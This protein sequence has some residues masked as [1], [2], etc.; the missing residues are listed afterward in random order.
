MPE[1]LLLTIKIASGPIVGAI[2]GFF[3]NWLAVKMLFRPYK[4]K[5]IGKFR[6]PFTPGIIPKRKEALGRALGKAVGTKLITPEDLKRLF[7]GEEIKAKIGA[8]IAD[9]VCGINDEVTARTLVNGFG[10]G[11]A[12]KIADKASGFISEKMV[13]AVK[14][15]DL[16]AL[17]SEHAG[18]ALSSVGGIASVIGM[19]GGNKL[20]TKLSESVGEKL[21]KYIDE[22]GYELLCPIVRGEIDGLLDSSL[23]KAIDTVGLTREKISAFAVSV[24]EK[25]VL[26]KVTEFVASFDIAG[27]VQQKVEEMSMKEIE[28]LFMAVM[29]KELSAI[30]NLGGLLGLLVGA[31]NSVINIFL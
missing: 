3:T 15:L 2:I 24:Y 14:K 12:E 16:P 30:I 28:D 21:E 13:K 26:D 17:I 11:N 8:I 5:Y 31:I 9:S 1:W 29:K 20:M 23:S 18:D 27:I 25:Y 10:E 7:T 4:A 6:L 19:F 22:N